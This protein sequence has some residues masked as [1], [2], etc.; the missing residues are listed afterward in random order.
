[1]ARRQ[2]TIVIVSDDNQPVRQVRLSREAARVLIALC[3]FLLAGVTS[4]ATAFFVGN[5]SEADSKLVARN[6]LLE[7][8]LETITLKLDTL[9][10]SL[11]KLSEKDEYYRLLA[12]L[13]PLDPEMMLAGIGGPDADSMEAHPLY[14]VDSRVGRRA[15]TT[16]TELSSLLRRA[17]LL[18]SSWR[19]A[20]D[21]LSYKKERMASTPSINPTSG[22][23]SSMFTS[24]RQHP[25]LD[26]PRAHKGLDIVAP[27]GTAVVASANGRVISS[28]NDGG[29]GL[30]IQIDHGHGLL[31]RY[32][33]LSRSAVS[34]GQVVKR[35]DRIGNVG[36]SGL[37]VGPHLH[38]EVLVNG[39]AANPRKYI[40][41]SDVIPD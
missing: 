34:A 23:V 35:G 1:M 18:T 11:G 30:M 26:R 19:E 28:V 20:E 29:Y 36:M 21:T 9:Q 31:T 7:S 41:N 37:A 13:D 8:E 39:Q 15:F 16:A 22:Y 10:V 27:S 3:L 14:R 12:G 38:Y 32:A 24:S 5:E 33:H 40:L 4:L 6:Q 2:W 17:K 25:I